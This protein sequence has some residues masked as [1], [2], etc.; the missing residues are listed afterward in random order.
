MS[1]F[2]DEREME[3]W[4][5]DSEAENL[6]I[7]DLLTCAQMDRSKGLQLSASLK[8]TDFG[9]PSNRCLF[10]VLRD[11]YTND[12]V[13]EINDFIAQAA[14]I[15]MRRAKCSGSEAIRH[16]AHHIRNITDESLTVQYSTLEHRIEEIGI[17]AAIAEPLIEA[18]GCYSRIKHMSKHRR[19]KWL[20][21]S[22]VEASLQNEPIGVY[23]ERLK[24]LTGRRP[25]R[26][27][28]RVVI[29]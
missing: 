29:V 2:L 20:A 19:V 10:S 15:W 24:E 1:I 25:K 5:I 12:R 26:K 9:I 18:E 28:Q 7:V 4:G 16:I 8:D 23:V 27:N 13:F 6:M 3:L 17:Q 11:L 21:D 14:H 22:I